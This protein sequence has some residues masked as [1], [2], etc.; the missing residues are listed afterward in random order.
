MIFVSHYREVLPSLSEFLIKSAKESHK[1]DSGHVYK[2]TQIFKL[3][4]EL[5]SRLGD[6]A[7]RLKIHERELWDILEAAKPYLSKYQHHDLQVIK[8]K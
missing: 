6:V 2:Y 5:L 1:K 4:K 8:V 7:E 3:Q